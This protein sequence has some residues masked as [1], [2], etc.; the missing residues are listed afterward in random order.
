MTD[1]T[2]FLAGVG[3]NVHM[4]ATTTPYGNVALTQASLAYVG[5]GLIRDHAYDIDLA[6]FQTLSAAGVG[7]DLILDDDPKA[8]IDSLL[9]VAGAIRSFEG[10]NEVDFYPFDASGNHDPVAA[11]AEQVRVLAAVR[12]TPQVALLPVYASSLADPSNMA[13]YAGTLA[14]ATHATL[15]AY[16]TGGSGPRGVLEADLAIARSLSALPAVVTETGYYTLP[17][18]EHGV[19]ETV[20][21]KLTLDTL[22]DAQSLGIG[23]TFLYELFDESA[24]PSGTD[25]ELHYGLFRVDGSAKPVATALHNLTTILASANATTSLAPALSITTA[26]LPETGHTMVLQGAAGTAVVAIWAEPSIWNAQTHAPV[27][28]PSRAVTVDLGVVAG[29]VAVFDP[30]IGTSA[31]ATYTGVSSVVVDVT[32][33][34]LLIEV[35]AQASGNVAPIEQP[36]GQPIE[37]PTARSAGYPTYASI[38]VDRFFDTNSGTHFYTASAAE[39]A[40]VAQTRPDLLAEGIGLRAIDASAGDPNA[41]PI[42]RFFDL[43]S[44]THFFT[45]SPTERDDVMTTR[46]DMLYEAGNVFYEHLTP[47][48]GDVAVYRFFDTANGTHFYTN[49]ADERATLAATRADLVDEG[50]G[51]YEPADN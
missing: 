35:T 31:V 45:A 44:G 9:P 48:L 16:A 17:S 26:N 42:Y 30:L 41:V 34:P 6:A 4:D 22:F 20:Q 46:A 13:A 37:P 36:A 27:V 38:G 8:E 43:S 33:H 50:V 2:Q 40:Q 49:S 14:F 39:A 7:L 19:D 3:V 25:S 10:P 18:D 24:D 15:H 1:I 11:L 51:F 47:Q 5:I 29:S 23:K 28:A 21:A 32:D 12:S